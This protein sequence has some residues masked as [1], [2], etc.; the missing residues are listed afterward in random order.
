MRACRKHACG[1]M[2]CSG[3]GCPDRLPALHAGCCRS[4][5]RLGQFD[6]QKLGVELEPVL[7]EHGDRMGLGNTP[8]SNAEQTGLNAGVGASLLEYERGPVLQHLDDQVTHPA[9]VDFE[10]DHSAQLFNRD[11]E[12]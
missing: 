4:C 12:F 10:S 3:R 1:S 6:R 9:V 7:A 5:P 11:D 2:N 8:S